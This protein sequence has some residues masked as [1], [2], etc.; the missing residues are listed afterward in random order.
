M[1]V[2]IPAGRSREVLKKVRNYNYRFEKFVKQEGIE[3]GIVI[4][5]RGPLHRS[6]DLIKAIDEYEL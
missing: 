6:L 1:F 3:E 4:Q 2:Y 5:I